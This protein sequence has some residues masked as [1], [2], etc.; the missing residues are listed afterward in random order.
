MR[1]EAEVVSALLAVLNR[2]TPT[3]SVFE[4]GKRMVKKV[5]AVEFHT[6]SKFV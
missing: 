4:V 5:M 3:N 6:A 2:A 1:S